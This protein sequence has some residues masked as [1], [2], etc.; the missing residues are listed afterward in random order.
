MG[1]GAALRGFGA[2]MKGGKKSPTISSVKPSIHKT[3]KAQKTSEMKIQFNKQK[4]R[5]LSDRKMGKKEPTLTE[6]A[7]RK[8]TTRE[9]NEASKKMFD[10]ANGK[11]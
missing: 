1:I 8:L 4:S 2:I 3:K 6:Y 11:K 10:D 9:R 5:T 7:N